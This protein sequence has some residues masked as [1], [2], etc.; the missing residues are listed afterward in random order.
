MIGVPAG[1]PASL[2]AHRARRAARRALDRARRAGSA[3]APMALGAR[4]SGRRHDRPDVLIADNG[5]LFGV[6]D[7]R[8][9]G[10]VERQ[11]QRLRRR[12]LAARTT[13]T[14]RPRPRPMR[15]GRLV[16]RRNRIETEVPGLGQAALRRDQRRGRRRRRT[17]P[18]RR[19][20]IAPNWR[21]RRRTGRASS[22]APRSCGGEGRWRSGSR[23]GGL[24]VAGARSLNRG[25]PWTRDPE[26]GR[27]QA[28]KS[29]PRRGK[30]SHAIRSVA[31]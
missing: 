8:G 16:R 30:T 5:R 14:S 15:A 13:A 10:A 2:G 3:L 7:R 27:V 23:R 4:C 17:A 20:L 11:G 6:A 31:Y 28:G 21:E 25:R 24:E 1:P 18:R 9:A 29:R 22:S 19:S 26:R 12:E